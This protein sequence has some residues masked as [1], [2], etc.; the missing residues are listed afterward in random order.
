M[1]AKLKAL[2]LRDT[3][4]LVDH[5]IVK[6]GRVLSG[7]WVFRLKTA[8]DETIKRFKARWV[9]RGYDQHHGIDFD[10]TF[11]PVSRHTSVR[12]LLDIAIAKHLPLRQIDVKNAFL[13]ALVDATNFVEQPH[14]YGEGD[15]RVCRPKK[16]LYGIK[17]APRLWQQHLHK[18]LLDIGF[19]QLPHDPRTYRLH[20]N[21]AYILLTV[22]VDNLLYTSTSNSL[23]HQFEQNLA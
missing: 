18:I 22:Y 10:Q 4:V 1:D 16:S 9:V 14:T 11:A 5:A 13:Y 2:E 12:I 6:R 21:G 8:A 7:K 23:L 20:F 3:W 19:K 15:P 17:Q